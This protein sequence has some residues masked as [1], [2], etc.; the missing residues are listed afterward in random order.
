MTNGERIKY[1]REKNGLT[2]KDIATRLGVESAAISKYELD[3]REPNI[4][5]LKKL[6]TIFNVS[7]DYLLGRTPDVFVNESDRNT[8]Y[9]SIIQKKYNQ[10][11]S[12]ID[13]IKD[14]YKNENAIV[15]AVNEL[16]CGIGRTTYG[17]SKLNANISISEIDN[18]FNDFENSKDPKPQIMMK[19]KDLENSIIIVEID[20]FDDEEMPLDAT[21][22]ITLYTAKLSQKYNVLGLVMTIDKDE[23][24]KIIDAIYQ[25]NKDTYYTQLHLPKTILTAG[26]YID[27]MSRL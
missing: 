23:N 6:A 24:C 1:L 9:I 14:Y 5:A 11:K 16:C 27:I 19:I 12:K 3:M 10:L 7:I 15:I 4:E 2:Q 8:L 22:R 18:I 26:E 17:E 21:D 25:K 13:N 20:S